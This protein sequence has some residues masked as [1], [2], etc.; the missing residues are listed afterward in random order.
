[1]SENSRVEGILQA[2]IDGGEYTDIPQSRVE[3]LLIELKEVIEEGGGGTT[4]EANPEGEATDDLTKIKIGNTIYDILSSGGE[5]IIYKADWIKGS[6]TVYQNDPL[7]NG[8]SLKAGKYIIII[9]A[10]SATNQASS[11]RSISLYDTTHSKELNYFYIYNG[12]GSAA[13]TLDISEDSTIE[14]RN[15][16]GFTSYWS[17]ADPNYSGLYAVPISAIGGGGGGGGT[18]V[19][20][21]PSG[22]ATED[23]ETIKIG[24]TIYD[25]PGS[26][27]SGGGSS[28]TITDVLWSGSETTSALASPIQIENLNIDKYDILV[29]QANGGQHLVLI[30]QILEGDSGGNATIAVGGYPVPNDTTRNWAIHINRTGTTLRI[31]TSTGQSINVTKILGVKFCGTLAPMIYSL[32]EREVGVWVDDK[33][34]YQRT[35]DKRSL[36]LA[37]SAWS[38]K[39]LG[40]TGIHIVNY[41]GYFC[42]GADA[43]PTISYS[44]YRSSSEYF[45]ATVDTSYSDINVRPNMNYG[46]IYAGLITIW[47]TKDSDVPGSGS[48]GSLGVPMVHYDDTEKVVGTYFGKTLYE[49]SYT[50]FSSL[51]GQ[52][53]TLDFGLSGID[54]IWYVSEGCVLSDGMY[55]F[56]YIHWDP[57]NTIGGY[58]SLNNGSPTFGF[59]AGSQSADALIN[60]FTIRY[61]KLTD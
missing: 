57:A 55:P 30:N 23:L 40:T 56:P 10:Q 47:Y 20:P 34:L 37:D 50:N 54:K 32:E 51:T 1:M 46:A 9:K 39:I 44:Y 15:P 21:N 58:W 17:L 48:Y 16:S 14:V 35:F 26:G 60:T 59:R 33:P 43:E 19:V 7:T 25:I 11:S 28:Q 29:V 38:N 52:S 4:V 12:W 24:N 6:G 53:R 49:K 31:F 42:L 5:P 18:T 13:A 22:E 61:T 8:L 36:Y 3:E 45:T 41:E 2:T 27:S